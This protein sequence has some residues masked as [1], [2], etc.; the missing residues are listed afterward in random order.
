MLPQ[1]IHATRFVLHGLEMPLA[2]QLTEAVSPSG[3]VDCSDGSIRDCVAL[4][5]RVGA[6]VIFCDSCPR[7]YRRLLEAL[8]RKRLGVPV[9]VVSRLPEVSEWLD[10]MEAGAMDYCGAPFEPRQIRWLLELTTLPSAA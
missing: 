10:A 9:V 2:K 4:A 5:E 7:H 1:S 8:R 6:R 3:N